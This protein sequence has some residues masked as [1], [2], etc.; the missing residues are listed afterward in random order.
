MKLFFRC[1]PEADKGAPIGS[2]AIMASRIGRR[3]EIYIDRKAAPCRYGY[4]RK[5][6]KP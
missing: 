2:L 4:Q 3:P 5:Y 6:A 1:A